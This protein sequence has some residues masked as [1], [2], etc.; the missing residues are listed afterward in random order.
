MY[1]CLCLD[2][3]LVRGPGLF[4]L[5]LSPTFDAQHPRLRLFSMRSGWADFSNFG[6]L[7]GCGLLGLYHLPGSYTRSFRET[8]LHH[9][10][11][12]NRLSTSG[13]SVY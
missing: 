4:R 10:A 9:T 12:V 13:H 5:S 2:V 7:D 8:L 6:T 3:T 1:V 11:V